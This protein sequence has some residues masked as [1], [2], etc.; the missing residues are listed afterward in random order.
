MQPE[1]PLLQGDLDQVRE[2]MAAL[3]RTGLTEMFVDLNFDQEV[4]SPDADP[5]ASRERADEVLT[6]LAPSLG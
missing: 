1:R 3:A 4:G 5:R 6:A 2:D